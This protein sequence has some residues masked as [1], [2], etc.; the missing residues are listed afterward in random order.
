MSNQEQNLPQQEQPFV[1]AKQV[2]FNLEDIILNTNNEVDLLY[3]EHT[4]KAYFKCV[5]YFISK[6]CLRKPFIKSPNMYQEYLAEFWYSAK[7]LENSKMLL[8]SGFLRLG[9]GKRFQQKELLE[10]LSFLL[11]TKLGAKT[12][13][14]KPATSKQPSVSSKKATKGGSSKAPTGSKTGHSKR[15]KKSNSAMDSN[16]SR[17]SVSTPV[18][19][20]IHKEDQQATG[21]P[22]SLG[23]TSKERTNPQLSSDFT[24]K[25]D[26]GLSAPND[27]IPPQQG[28]DEGTKNTLYD[29]ISTEKEVSFTTI[30]G[31]KEEASTDI[32]GDKEEASSTIK[33][34]ELA[35]LVSQIQP[36]FK[37]LD[38]PKDNH[39]I[40]VDESDEYESTAET[41]ESLSSRSSQIQE[42]TNQV[43]I[44]QS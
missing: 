33:L 12:R 23:V 11:S 1:A 43:L 7:A 40:I 29:H 4:N 16:P 20:K 19:T 28:M 3:P 9:M 30:Y 38:S 41:K 36:N 39:V 14:K 8:G 15:R 26:I 6:C 25:V 35:K 17:P 24:A 18:D 44:L 21:G 32:H 22:T 10:R 5:T 31:D 34:E 37:D 27:S 13:H 2:S 42:L